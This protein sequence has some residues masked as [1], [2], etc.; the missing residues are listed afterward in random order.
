[1]QDQTHNYITQVDQLKLELKDKTVEF[2]TFTMQVNQEL[3]DEK[4]AHSAK[5]DRVDKLET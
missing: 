3:L 5:Q 1:V 2:E 4:E